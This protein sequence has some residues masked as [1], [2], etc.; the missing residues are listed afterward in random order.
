MQVT[1]HL[2]NLARKNDNTQSSPVKVQSKPKNADRQDLPPAKF[3][4]VNGRTAW[5]DEPHPFLRRD[6]HGV[7]LLVCCVII[8][9][10]RG[11]PSALRR[12]EET[13]PSF[14]LTRPKPFVP[15]STFCNWH[16]RGSL[17]HS[18]CVGQSSHCFSFQRQNRR[19]F[20]ISHNRTTGTR[21]HTWVPYGAA[22]C[23]LF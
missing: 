14:R 10:R 12:R 9:K 6:G 16:W 4:E 7:Y 3:G 1:Y 19:H 20:R 21:E 17:F 5:S 22:S 8:K 18:G 23:R 15:S 11:D 13:P 2:E